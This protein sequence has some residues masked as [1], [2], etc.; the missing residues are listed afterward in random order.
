MA[1]GN[2][3]RKRSRTSVKADE[4]TLS[5]LT[6]TS[7]SLNES[8]RPEEAEGRPGFYDRQFR[9]GE[10][11]DLVLAST[12]LADEIAMLRVVIRRCF[13]QVTTDEVSGI[14]D[15]VKVLSALSVASARL[16]RLVQAQ[17]TLLKDKGDDFMTE[18]S[19]AL[20]EARKRMGIE[21]D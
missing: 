8:Q 21:E 12:S 10:V 17:Q 3:E 5:R 20:K 16:S 7:R 1:A 4:E 2:P 15:W 9:A 11:A 18:F 19:I 6:S 14:E 13:E